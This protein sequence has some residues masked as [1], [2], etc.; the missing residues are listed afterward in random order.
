MYVKV[1]N[2][3]MNTFIKTMRD[4]STELSKELDNMIKQMNRL[5][6]EVWQGADARTFNENVTTYLE[7]MKVIPKA[8]TTLSNISDKINKG[9]AEN[10][11]AFAK[12][13]EE[14]ANR[15]AK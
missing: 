5:T 6:T 10:D 1:D 12:A 15:Y 14:V 11:E 8:I 7:K 3:E 13:L 9:Y 4:D 2:D